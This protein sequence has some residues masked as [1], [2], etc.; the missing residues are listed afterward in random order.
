MGQ[1][2]TEGLTA[3]EKRVYEFIKEK[4]KATREEVMANFK[5]DEAEMDAQILPLMRLELVKEQSEGDQLYL[6]LVG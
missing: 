1:K 4:G 2:G 6:V 5:L 3:M